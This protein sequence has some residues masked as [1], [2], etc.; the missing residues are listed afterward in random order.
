M[1][2]DELSQGLDK[3]AQMYSGAILDINPLG[4]GYINDTYLIEADTFSFVLQKINSNVFPNPEQIMGNLIVLNQ[5]IK[6]MVTKQNTLTIPELLLTQSGN[7]FYQD[8]QNEYW[9]ALSYIENTKSLE[10][11]GNFAEA[12]QVGVALGQFH[13]LTYSLDSASL[14][15]TLPGFHITSCYWGQY[16][17]IKSHASVAEDAYCKDFIDR[18]QHIIHDLEAAKKQGLLVDRVIHGDPKL[19]NFLFDKTSKRIVSLIDLDTV[20]PG[21]IHYDIGD[22]LRS[23][24]HKTDINEFDLDICRVILTSYLQEMGELF[25]DKDYQ[26]LY[27]C[28]RLIPFELGIRFYAD[29][30]DG[31]RYFKVTEPEENLRRATGQFQLCASVMGQEV[32]INNLIMQLQ[33][34]I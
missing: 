5:H 27:S 22:C 15:D 6:A 20:K 8:E 4:N 34:N 1:A 18:W 21:L 29:Y 32:E 3:I 25:S 31:N 17:Q 9:R 13:R 30:L 16:Q 28:I 23:S 33:Q 19:N 14:F 26:F 2:V 12:E 11:L 7:S 10:T 24:C